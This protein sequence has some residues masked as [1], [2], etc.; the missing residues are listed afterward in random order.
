[1]ID[2]VEYW[3][4]RC[5]VAERAL[6]GDRWGDCAK[7]LTL[8]ETRLLK[9]LYRRP[10][11]P[12]ELADFLSLENDD[13]TD[14]AVRTHVSRLR[15]KLGDGVLSRALRGDRRYSIADRKKVR[16]LLKIPLQ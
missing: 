12:H 9:L 11:S 8:T 14:T 10:M 5:M 3:R 6:K 2:D 13:I 4:A 7:G 16:R 1:M 15:T